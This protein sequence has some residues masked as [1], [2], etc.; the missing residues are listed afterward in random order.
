MKGFGGMSPAQLVLARAMLLSMIGLLLLLSL[1]PTMAKSSAS[2]ASS[3]SFPRR[4]RIVIGVDGGTESIRACCF[5]AENGRVVGKSCAVPYPTY[6][7]QP[8]WAE[9]DPKD[10]W[11]NL[12]QAVRGAV[13]SIPNPRLLE[14]G[15]D[16]VVLVQICSICVDTTC[17]SVVALDANNEPLR[18][19]LLWMDARSAP[20]TS[21]APGKLGWR[22][23]I[24]RGM[25]DAK[26][27]L[28]PTNRTRGVGT[29]QDDL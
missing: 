12:G 27:T 10:W 16:E 29:S 21:R 1:S 23:P 5:D 9:Q 3:A 4:K 7:P 14:D 18:N 6:H 11:E 28:D 8:G 25:D 20:Q 15:E 2:S 19:C 13:D 22:R 26:S 24:V 17:C